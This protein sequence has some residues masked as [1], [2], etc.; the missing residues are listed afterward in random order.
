[1]R[2]KFVEHG[3]DGSKFEVLPHFQKACPAVNRAARR[4]I[5]RCCTSGRLSAEKGVDDLLRAM[6]QVPQMRLII[7]GDGPQRGELQELAASLGIGQCGVC[8]T[9]RTVRN[10]TRLIARS[11]VYGAAFARLRDSGENHPGI[12]RGGASG[13]GSDLGSRREFVRQGETGFLYRYG[14]VNQL[15]EAIRVAGGK[16]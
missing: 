13:G 5:G 7:A 16:S 4:T 9:G 15:A 8:G 3:W 10:G 2:D 12:V 6:Q 14:D 11:Q 1:M